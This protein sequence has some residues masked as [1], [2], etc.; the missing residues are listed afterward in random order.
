MKTLYLT[1]NSNIVVDAENGTCN[2][3]KKQPERISSVFLA[4]EP[5]RVVYGYDGFNDDVTVNKG[6]IIITFY[7]SEFK[8]RMIVVHSSEWAEILEDYNQKQQEEKER[9][10]SEN[11]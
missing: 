6:D 8:K 4:E 9:W 5:M 3:L 11:L 10:A 1:E 7:S 2:T